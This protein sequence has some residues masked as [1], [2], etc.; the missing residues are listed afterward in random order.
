MTSEQLTAIHEEYRRACEAARDENASPEARKNAADD[1]LAKRH[2][3]D[4]ALIEQKT[5]QEDREREAQ[6]EQ[7][8]IAAAKLVAGLPP[9][10]ES[11]FPLEAIRAYGQS[12]K[13]KETLSFVMPFAG[14]MVHPNLAR[15]FSQPQGADWTTID[16]TTY[17]SYTVPQTWASEVY[18]FQVAMSGVLA[19]GPT[20]LNTTNGNQINYPKLVTDMSSA[21]GAEGTAATETNPV[22]GTTP[23]N[24]YRIDGWTPIADE[25]FRDSGVNIEA[26]LRTLAARSLAIKAAPYYADIDIG[27][28]SSLPAAITIGITNG[29][30]S[31]SQTA[32]TMDEA[33]ELYSS[34]LPQYRAMGSWI[35]NSTISLA[36]RLMKDGEGRY[37]WQPAPSAAEPDRFYGKPWFEDAYFDVS[38]SGNIPL[39]FGDVAQ[40][41]IVRRIGGIQVDL[42]RDFAF[43]SFETTARW[44]MYHDAATIDTIA[45]KALTLA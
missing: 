39:I 13:P 33:I 22:F 28:G 17:S 7:A 12:N 21:A 1:M 10:V 15:Q 18:M 23:L 27:T 40:A 37:L 43:T 45:C 8:R 42:S 16:T 5:E 14:P 9:V 6:V 34:L 2:E 24:S 31:A 19:A 26:V 29:K 44:A 41:Y 35:G 4:A 3:P 38:A 36:F 32:P 11:P 30:T 25:L 20:I